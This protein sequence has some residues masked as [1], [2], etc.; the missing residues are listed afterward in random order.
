MSLPKRFLKV[1][2]PLASP[3]QRL[4]AAPLPLLD[5]TTPLAYA[6]ARALRPL[7]LLNVAGVSFLEVG[8]LAGFLAGAF[9]SYLFLC[10][11]LSS[12]YTL[13]V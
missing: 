13:Q 5:F 9:H 4:Y 3:D 10:K 11:N 1:G 6:L 2:L 7:R 8:L 12:F